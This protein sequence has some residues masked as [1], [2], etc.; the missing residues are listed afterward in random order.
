M[1]GS[2]V[3]SKGCFQ[4]ALQQGNSVRNRLNC[5]Q[6]LFPIIPTPLGRVE[7]EESETKLILERA[8]GKKVLFSFIYIYRYLTAFLVGN[9][10]NKPS[11]SLFCP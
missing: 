9:K 5:L 3:R 10:L 2:S 6:P 4:L 11:P 1:E 7:A 8:C